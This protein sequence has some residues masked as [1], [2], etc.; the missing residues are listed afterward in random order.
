MKKKFAVSSGHQLTTEAATDI[1]RA[2][3]NAVDAAIAAFFMTWVA[4]PCMSSGGGG[5]F[6][7]IFSAKGK[8]HLYDFFCQTP[9]S[10]RP[11]TEVDFYPVT[12]DFGDMTEEF[13]IGRGST[14]VP[15]AVAGVFAMHDDFGTIPMRELVQPAMNAARNGIQVVPFQQMDFRLLEPILAAEEKGRELFFKND[16][17][18]KVGDEMKMPA[19]ADFLDYLSR[20][21]KNA[22]YKG[23]IAQKIAT[24]Y[25]EKGGFLTLEDF[26]NYRVSIKKPLQFSYRDYSILTNPAPAYGG[27]LIEKAM[28]LIEN[29]TIEGELFSFEHLTQ[30]QNV[31]AQTEKYSKN[32]NQLFGSDR[33]TISHSQRGNTTHLSIVDKDGNAVSLTAS[34][35]EGCGYFVENTDIQLNNMLGEAALLPAGFHS[36]QPDTR[37]PSM[38]SP[39]LVLDK[40]EELYMVTGS[41]GAGRIA[42]AIAQTLHYVLDGKMPIEQAVNAP[43]MHVAHG[44]LNLEPNWATV[45]NPNDFEHRIRLWEQQSLFFGGVNAITCND[46]DLRAGADQRRDGFVS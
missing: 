36:W 2:G 18:V 4:E 12:V 33:N 13:Q 29:E 44:E 45:S 5:G 28:Q 10:K 20:E 11:I 17:L 3:G 9:I 35:G 7:N 34:N 46:D 26:E 1:L 40:M 37:L 41:S 23:E 16:K 8:A 19:M 21:G 6:A 32:P 25:K 39:T 15:G 14:G 31:F 42:P 38:M 24:D 43:R 30:L 27:L 22:F